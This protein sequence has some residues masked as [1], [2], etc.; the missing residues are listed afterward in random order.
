[1]K[2]WKKYM[3]IYIPIGLFCCFINFCA[4]KDNRAPYVEY[5]LLHELDKTEYSVND[6]VTGKNLGKINF[7]I[8]NDEVIFDISAEA[9]S[10]TLMIGEYGDFYHYSNIDLTNIKVQKQKC[11]NLDFYSGKVG[12]WNTIVIMSLDNNDFCEYYKS[13]NKQRYLFYLLKNSDYHFSTKDESVYDLYS[14]F[15]AFVKTM[16][17]ASILE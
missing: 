13:K 2:T 4:K 3:L 5:H 1:M 16:K 7:S 9:V 8:D 11:K 14:G 10:G 6:L 15:S 17:Y 12:D